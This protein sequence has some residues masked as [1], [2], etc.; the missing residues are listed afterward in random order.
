MS[1]SREVHGQ[2]AVYC[3]RFGETDADWV[4]AT[5]SI[6]ALPSTCRQLRAE[7]YLLPFTSENEFFGQTGWCLQVL[8]ERLGG[9]RKML[10]RE[11]RITF[12]YED[13]E[14]NNYGFGLWRALY[15]TLR[16]GTRAAA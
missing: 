1:Y 3:R 12:D 14:R 15:E 5:R 7:T 4:E 11:G 13:L 16:S 2:K 9:H 10:V 6:T 8:L